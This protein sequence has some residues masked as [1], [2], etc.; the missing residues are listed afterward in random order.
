MIQYCRYCRNITAGDYYCCVKERVLSETTI[1]HVNRCPYFKFTKYDA[2]NPEHEYTPVTKNTPDPN[3][4]KL[5][6]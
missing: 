2:V 3:Q 5:E 4:G 6:F 1:K